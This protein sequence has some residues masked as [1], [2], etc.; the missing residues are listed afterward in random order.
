MAMKS[1]SGP[2]VPIISRPE[3]L[4]AKG[5][6]SNAQ[7]DA[8]LSKDSKEISKA[9]AEVLALHTLE[10][11][12][13]QNPMTPIQADT[14]KSAKGLA[15]GQ[16][17][18]NGEKQTK[19][20]EK[21]N[22]DLVT[23]F[24]KEGYKVVRGLVGKNECMIISSLKSFVLGKQPDFQSLYTAHQQSE[25]LKANPTSNMD[26]T[27]S[28][29]ADST[30]DSDVIVTSSDDDA[31]NTPFNHLSKKTKLVSHAAQVEALL[32]QLPDSKAF[33]SS[34]IY[35]TLFKP[36]LKGEHVSCTIGNLGENKTEIILIH[37]GNRI[38]A[39]IRLPGK[40][41]A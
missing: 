18:L 41:K 32:T 38:D 13:D 28:D 7:L 24:E 17:P 9:N 29:E 2:R 21:A 3:E 8:A 15:R 31:D 22:A 20:Q 37:Y 33:F 19:E 36:N 23:H 5:F 1:L 4:H 6:I 10:D 34:N 40:T 25:K 16:T 12:C 11:F 27:E 14:V 39:A 30:A 26:G 35:V